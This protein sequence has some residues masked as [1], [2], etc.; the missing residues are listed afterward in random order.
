MTKK[1]ACI[2]WG[3][4]IW[5]PRDLLVQRE[6]F[7]DGALLPVE[8]ARQAFKDG[9]SDYYNKKTRLRTEDEAF[10]TF[11]D[12]T[13]EFNAKFEAFRKKDKNGNNY[14]YKHVRC[15]ILHQGKTDRCWRIRRTGKLFEET[16]PTI[17]ADEFLTEL[18]KVLSAYTN[19][20]KNDIN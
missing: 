5:D 4:L 13:A 6:W 10:Q 9:V 18:E 15:G 8:F 16:T 12:N 17:N 11:F 20:L 2:G 3:S 1:I 14:F 19:Q 7:K